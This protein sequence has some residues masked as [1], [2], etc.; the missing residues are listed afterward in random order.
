MSSRAKSIRSAGREEERSGRTEEL[1]FEYE[2]GLK[3]L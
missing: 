2:G 1:N 3:R